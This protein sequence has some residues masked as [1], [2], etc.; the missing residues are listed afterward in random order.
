MQNPSNTTNNDYVVDDCYY[1]DHRIIKHFHIALD[2]KIVV[3]YNFYA[4]F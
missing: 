1:G 4:S 3:L 2:C